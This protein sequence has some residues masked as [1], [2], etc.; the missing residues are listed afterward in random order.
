MPEFLS[1]GT[2]R[3]FSMIGTGIGLGV[4]GFRLPSNMWSPRS[5]SGLLAWYDASDTSTLYQSNGG[6]LAAANGDPVG[7]WL[8]KSSN[9]RHLT[10]ASGTNKPALNTNVQNGRTA[11]KFDGVNDSIASSAFAT[12]STSRWA[13]CVFKT[14]GSASFWP[15]M[16]HGSGDAT[17]IFYL[18]T[19]NTQ[20]Y[21]DIGTASGPY[22]QPTSAFTSGSYLLGLVWTRPAGSSVLNVSKNGSASTPTVTSP[23]TTPNTASVA[24]TVGAS[25]VRFGAHSICEIIYGDGAISASDQAN[26]ISYLNAKWA[27]Y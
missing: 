26:A 1:V 15:V 17:D 20:F 13:F 7:Y 10:Q 18:E 8:D 23:T 24:L 3:G 2:N 21:N 19:S 22:S 4:S 9:A 27:V 16:C 11:V 6:S 12:S 25:Y 5:I 14:A